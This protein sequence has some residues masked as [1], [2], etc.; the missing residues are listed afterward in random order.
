VRSPG[1]LFDHEGGSHRLAVNKAASSET[2]SILFQEAYSGR[3]EIGLA[4]DGGF[5][6]KTSADGAAW[7]DALRADPLT[8]RVTFPGGAGGIAIPIMGNSG[9]SVGAGQTR[10]LTP[11][12]NSAYAAVVYVPVPVAGRFFGMTCITGGSPGP[13]ESWTFTLQNLFSDTALACTI[14]AGTNQG[15]NYVDAVSFDAQARWCIKMVA[16]AGAAESGNVLF[17]L[18]FAPD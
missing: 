14:P 18:L 1:T 11:G 9:A 17:S 10:F 8:G 7:H 12:L 15:S 6:L 5:A 13:G 16:T 2:A 3:A 4:G